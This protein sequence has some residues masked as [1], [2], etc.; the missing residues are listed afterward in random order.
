MVHPSTTGFELKVWDWVQ[1]A[2]VKRSEKIAVLKRSLSCM[3]TYKEI[4]HVRMRE[5]LAAQMAKHVQELEDLNEL[6]GDGIDVIERK[7]LIEE[8]AGS[9]ILQINGN[10]F[11]A[12][13]TQ[14]N[15]GDFE[16]TTGGALLLSRMASNLSQ[17]SGAHEGT[18]KLRSSRRKTVSSEVIKPEDLDD[19]SPPENLTDPEAAEWIANVLTTHPLFEHLDDK[20]IEALAAAMHTVQ[21]DDDDTIFTDGETLAGVS[22]LYTG[23]AEVEKDERVI[24][25]IAPGA[26]EGGEAL[27]YP[28]NAEFT[29]RAKGNV[30]LFTL[31]RDIYKRVATRASQEKRRTFEGFLSRIDFLEALT[32]SERLQVAD[33]L[34]TT[35]YSEGDKVITF[36]Q[37]GDYF[38]II[39]QG[40]VKVIGHE[41]NEEEDGALEEVDV[42][43]F[44]AGECVGELEFINGHK[45]CADVVALGMVKTAKMGRRHFEKLMGPVEEFLKDRYK[46]CWKGGEE[47]IFLGLF[48]KMRF[49][50]VYSPDRYCGPSK[51]WPNPKSGHNFYQP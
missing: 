41:P 22:L 14:K 18:V 37:E 33:A 44:S 48:L 4:R 19:F 15:I 46:V 20:D 47:L 13:Y 34:K 40:T 3:E 32:D 17:E 29:L 31:E 23:E 6:H 26:C 49:L 12:S 38:H 35:V 24:R 28:T 45:T 43:S 36:G 11:G 7:P 10:E 16:N 30:S 1:T 5:G 39:L 2:Q 8:E 9:P 27:M 50:S 51:L 25:T 21:V 42:C